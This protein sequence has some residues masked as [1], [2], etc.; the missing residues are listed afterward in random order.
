[1]SFVLFL[2]LILMAAVLVLVNGLKGRW[3]ILFMR[4]V[5]L[6]SSI[7]PIS[8]RV[9]LDLAKMWYSYNISH[10]KSIPDTVARNMMIPEDLGRV[11]MILSDKTGT[12]TQN[13]M[14][15]KAFFVGSHKYAKSDSLNEILEFVRNS[16]AKASGPMTD[17][18][19]SRPGKRRHRGDQMKDIVLSMA[20]CHNVTPVQ[21]DSVKTYQAASPDEVAL[22]RFASELGY[23]LVYRDQHVIQ[24]MTPS[25]DVDEYA[26]LK[27]FPF[28]S[29]S[30]KMGIIVQ[31]KKD[32]R[33]I[34]FLKGAEQ[35]L[36]PSLTGA[37][38][39]DMKEGAEDLSLEGLRT[40]SFAEK[41]LTQEEFEQWDADYKAAAAVLH[42][43]EEEKNRV[44]KALEDKMTY[45]GVTGVEDKL[46]ENIART[47]E[48]LKQ[49]GM[50]V[51]MLTGDKVETASCVGISSGIKSRSERYVHM[52]DVADDKY[53]IENELKVY[54]VDQV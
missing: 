54:F 18:E 33:I 46:Q 25:G 51:W 40:L 3:Q 28:S 24:V 45:L 48:G 7:I 43:R 44:R 30:K 8:L 26:I 27:D 42:N 37:E 23:E 4:F 5:L 2:M 36:E 12:L 49:A 22:V 52:K 35:A 10:D 34:Y 38:A 32:G 47:L 6:L 11:E 13:D 14:E 16:A 17:T 50:K 19:N 1:M 20:L 53:I 29:E 21:K 41:Q 15:F 39:N 31:Q 9:N